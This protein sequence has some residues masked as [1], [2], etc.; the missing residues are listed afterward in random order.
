ML[1]FRTELYVFK[2]MHVREEQTEEISSNAV[3]LH[4]TKK[5]K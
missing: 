3:F 4:N 1:M 5:I 2:F